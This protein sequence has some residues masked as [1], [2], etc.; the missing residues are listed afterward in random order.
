MLGPLAAALAAAI[1]AAC[2]ESG[3][4]PAAQTATQLVVTVQP[5]TTALFST[6]TPPV[7]VT[8]EDASGNVATGF[9]GAVT[10][11]LGANPADSAP[12][13]VQL[14]GA[15]TQTAVCGV[16]T[17]K[18]IGLNAAAVG[19]TLIASSGSL[20]PATTAP[21]T[22]MPLYS[23]IA[24]YNG[25]AQSGTASNVLAEPI[26]VIALNP[27]GDPFSGLLVHWAVTSGGGRVSLDST[28][29]IG[30]LASVEWVLGPTLGTQT[31]TATANGLTG[32]P[33]TFTAMAVTP[34]SD[35]V[36]GCRP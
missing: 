33:V 1:A 16:A 6:I 36:D 22:I 35:R 8:A 23:S 3:S 28:L 20:A 19:Y 4:A 32:S 5:S 12:V 29:T 34:H 15:V 13:R 21:F 25:N 18:G 31:A 24:V 17:F 10:L 7:V 9:G 30:G 27:L 2:S 11:T 26:A 14:V